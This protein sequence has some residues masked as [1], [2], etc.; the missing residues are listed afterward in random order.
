MRQVVKLHRIMVDEPFTN[1]GKS[2]Q[3]NRVNE[4][5]VTYSIFNPFFFET[6][7]IKKDIVDFLLISKS[8]VLE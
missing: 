4:K 1:D 8:I 2:E 7:F 6:V 5:K 3:N